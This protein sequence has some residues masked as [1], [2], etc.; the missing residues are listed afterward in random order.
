MEL[1]EA[2]RFELASLHEE[3]RKAEARIVSALGKVPPG[4]AIEGSALVEFQ[5]ADEEIAALRARIKVLEGLDE[6]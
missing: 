3:L 4:H 5:E 1:T 2:Q 6:R